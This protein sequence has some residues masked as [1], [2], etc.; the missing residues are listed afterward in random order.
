MR[1]NS[2]FNMKDKIND[3]KMH[4]ILESSS[5]KQTLLPFKAAAGSKTTQKLLL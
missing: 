3:I 4:L 5:Y 2:N 1:E